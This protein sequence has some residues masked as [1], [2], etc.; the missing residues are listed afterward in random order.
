M[1]EPLYRK[2]V[3]DQFGKH[4]DIVRAKV[5]PEYMASEVFTSGIINHTTQLPYH[6]DA[7]NFSGCWSL[8]LVLKSPQIGGGNLIIP[9][10]SAE[11]DLQNGSVVIFNG[12]ELLHG[13]SRIYNPDPDNEYRF[14]IVFYSMEQLW[15]C[16]SPT[17][18]LANVRKMRTELES[19]PRSMENLKGKKS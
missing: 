4:R 2:S 8:M 6:T 12:A 3:A 11:L 16:K 10:Y 9:E 14:S 5:R 19:R 18:E 7:G 15:Q 17:E 13:V 1:G